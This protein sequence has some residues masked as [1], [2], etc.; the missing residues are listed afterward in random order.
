MGTAQEMSLW[1]RAIVDPVFR[2]ELIEDPLRALAHADGVVVSSDQVRELEDMSP[3]ERAEQ[4]QRVMRDALA[5]RLRHQWG[6][7]FWTPDI[8]LDPPAD[9]PDIDDIDDD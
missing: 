8:G 5:R 1:A 7:R 9:E 3:D 4:L 6:D 2:D